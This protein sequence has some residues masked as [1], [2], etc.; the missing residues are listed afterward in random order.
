MMPLPGR[1]LSASLIRSGAETV[2]FDC[3]EGTQIAWRASGWPFRPTGTILLSHVD[4]D[5]VAGL[6]G[7]LFQIALSGRTE[8]V[9]IYGPARTHEIVT[10]LVSLIGWLP[11]ELRVSQ[12]D[13]GATLELFDELRLTTLAVQHG[14]PCL[15]YR[16]DLPRAPRFDPARARELGVPLEDWKRLQ[17]GES[18][19]EVR[20]QAVTGPPRRG[21]RLALVTDTRYFDDLVPFVQE[22]DLLICESMY[23]SDEE[24]ERAAER[25]HMTATQAARLAR[26]AG[27]RR[28]WL[29][30]L[31]PSVEDPEAV[32]AAAAS[33]FP[34]AELGRPGETLTLRF[35]DN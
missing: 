33:I 27:V 12:L 22:S 23:P 9:T 20:P 30:H 18:V 3:G 26:A 6:P 14:K 31:S 25:G 11:Y 19:G 2:L 8:P 29:T 17:R 28:L 7:V 15:A 24:I 5:H 13:G 32:R 4:A 21:L 35:P 10:H 16:L 34:E 1:W